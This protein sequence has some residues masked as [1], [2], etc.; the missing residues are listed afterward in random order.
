MVGFFR[1]VVLDIACSCAL[2]CHG[3][4][5]DGSCTS[6]VELAGENVM[7]HLPWIPCASCHMLFAGL[8]DLLRLG[9]WH[10]SP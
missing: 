5:D 1:A 9:W 4:F 2:Y 6:N 10:L 3:R 8:V 7:V